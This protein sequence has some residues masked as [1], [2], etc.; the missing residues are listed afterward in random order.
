[1]RAL[2]RT[3]AETQAG[4]LVERLPAGGLFH[5]FCQEGDNR[6]RYR[7]GREPGG[8]PEPPWDWDDVN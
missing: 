8:K 2:R 6:I 4:K 3:G 1:M 7:F 5:L